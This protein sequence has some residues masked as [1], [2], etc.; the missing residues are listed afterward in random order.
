MSQRVIAVLCF[1]AA[2]GGKSK[3]PETEVVEPTVPD[4]FVAEEINQEQ[5]MDCARHDL[6]L[7]VMA[8]GHVADERIFPG[9]CTGACT[10]EAKAEGEAQVA[11]IQARIDAGEGSYGELDY[12]FTACLF[13][14]VTVSDWEDLAVG[15]VAVLAGEE[16]W[17]H[18]IPTTYYH[19]ASER[20]GKVWVSQSF[21]QTNANTWAPEDLGIAEDNGTVQVLVVDG[22]QGRELYR[23]SFGEDP[24]AP[25]EET[26]GE[27]ESGF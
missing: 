7:R 26:V 11:E 15:E 1:A 27:A 10:P 3:P 5:E 4:G 22:E 14:G 16:P 20:C 12:N 6:A 25:P 9:E 21:G 18:D 24:C 13:H 23:V 17:P 19:L 2:C 8:G